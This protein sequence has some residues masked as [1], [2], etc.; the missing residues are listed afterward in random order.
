[1]PHSE[2]PYTPPTFLSHTFVDGNAET[3]CRRLQAH[4]AYA[5]NAAL[6]L[7]LNI[8]TVVLITRVFSVTSCL[9]L[10]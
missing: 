7:N 5:G 6:P 10:S 8:A 4:P 9:S 1:M 2:V 3:G